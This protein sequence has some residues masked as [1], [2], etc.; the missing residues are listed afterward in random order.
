MGFWLI[1]HGKPELPGGAKLCLGRTDVPLG[2]AGRLEAAL[3]GCVLS[4]AAVYSSPL[5]RAL[6]TAR[7]LADEVTVLPGLAERSTGEWDGL[8]FDEIRRRW[9]ELYER[10]GREPG[11]DMP[12]AE[13]AGEALARFSAALDEILARTPDGAAV[14][15]HAGVMELYLASLGADCARPPCGSVTLIE[16]GRVLSAGVLPRPELDD[17]VCRRL[18]EAAPIPDKVRAHC[19]AVADAAGEIARDTGLDERAVRSGA[20]LHDIARTLPHHP[21]AG[22]AWL[23]E[24]GYAGTAELVRRHNDHDGRV[25]DEAGAVCLADKLVLG[26]RRCSVTERFAASEAK[27]DTPEK[28]A[29]WAAR[30]AAAERLYELA[31]KKGARI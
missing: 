1:R 24:L 22:A 5:S 7:A 11:L 15:T 3:L 20:Y 26:T 18:L 10:R 12:G 17:A 23:E 9:P 14:V 31:V 8:S 4:P 6:D 25:L 13:P 19:A 29:A 16:G 2:G 28:H 21:Y 30:R 27:C